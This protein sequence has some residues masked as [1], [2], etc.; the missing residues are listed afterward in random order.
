MIDP[1]GVELRRAR[2]LRRRQ[3]SNRGPNALW[4]MDSYDKLKPYGIAINGCIDGFSGY[5]MWM[6]ANNTN[7][8]P[9][10]IADYFIATVARVGGCP[11]R[12]RADPGTE[13]SHVRDMQLFLRRNHS[14]HYASE[15]S[16]VYGCSTANQR[17]E[18]WWGIL[19]KQAGQFWMDIFQTLRDDGHFSGDFLDKNLIQFCFLN[20]IQEELDEVVRTWNSHLIRPRRGQGTHRGRPILMFCMPQIYSSGEDKIKSVLPEEVAVCKEECTPKDQYPCDETIFELCALL[21]DENGWD[22]PVDAYH[23]AEL[24][25]LL[26]TAREHIEVLENI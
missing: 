12:M 23:A 15:R 26:R 9:K 19:R 3:Y 21:I 10:V 17:I 22:A 11:E 6:E 8:D 2:R 5:V 24:Y 14:D 4:H 20:L 25:T 18:S 16:F 1:E 7:S 13:N